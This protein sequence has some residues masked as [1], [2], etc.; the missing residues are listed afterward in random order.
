MVALITLLASG[1]AAVTRLAAAAAA[2]RG[3]RGG[4]AALEG[5]QESV[6]GALVNLSREQSCMQARAPRA[7]AGRA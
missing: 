4:G 1:R 3:A 5:V 6:T 7:V 2:E